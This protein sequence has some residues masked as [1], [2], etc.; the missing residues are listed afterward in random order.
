MKRDP[1]RWEEAVGV[2]GFPQVKTTKN[3]IFFSVV[4]AMRGGWG[5][6]GGARGGGGGGGGG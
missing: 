3:T 5:R 2:D 1:R 6:G 4:S